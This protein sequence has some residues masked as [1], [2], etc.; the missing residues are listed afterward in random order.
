MSLAIASAL[1]TPFSE[2][3]PLPDR[4]HIS[5]HHRV[6]SERSATP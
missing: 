1:D 4:P 2:A 6:V 5:K 3:V